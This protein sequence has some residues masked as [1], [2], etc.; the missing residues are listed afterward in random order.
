MT[1][2][3]PESVRIACGQFMKR[4]SPPSARDPLGAGPQHQVIGVAEHDVARRSRRRSP[5]VIALT[6]AAVPTGMKAGVS[7][8]PCAV[9]EAAAARR[10]VARQDLEADAAH[11]EAPQW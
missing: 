4:C 10:A 9:V 3:P 8:V 5:G 2:K 7:I 1:W 6:V 11:R